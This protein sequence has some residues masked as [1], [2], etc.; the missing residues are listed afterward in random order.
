MKKTFIFF[1]FFLITNFIFSSF[2]YAEKNLDL[3]IKNE[4][5]QNDWRI[6]LI[7]NTNHP[8]N[9]LSNYKHGASYTI[10]Y[11]SEESGYVYIFVVRSN[12]SIELVYPTSEIDDNYLQ[13]NVLY[14]Y[15][16]KG[17]FNL[18]SPLGDESLVMYVVPEK[19]NPKSTDWLKKSFELRRC[20]TE[21]INIAF[22]ED[23]PNR[24]DIL[25]YF[26]QPNLNVETIS[27]FFL[28]V[29]SEFINLFK[30]NWIGNYVTYTVCNEYHEARALYDYSTLTS[31]EKIVKTNYL[32]EN[33]G[34]YTIKLDKKNNVPD[35]NALSKEIA[36]E[37]AEKAVRNAIYKYEYTYNLSDFDVFAGYVETNTLYND[38]WD[39]CFSHNIVE[40]HT[41]DFIVN[42]NATTGQIVH[43]CILDKTLPSIYE[44][45][46]GYLG[47]ERRDYEGN[48][49]VSLIYIEFYE[50]YPYSENIREEMNKH[51]RELGVIP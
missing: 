45:I 23:Y 9:I 10:N 51:E 6:N 48:Y 8:Q 18:Y 43:L 19:L 27:D 33:H 24:L 44:S 14:Y 7:S 41:V 17:F 50:G 34:E 39:I 46:D 20:M 35:D 25:S 2:V 5:S 22:Y 26:Y 30:D 11:K 4:Y 49:I 21:S 12:R 36:V 15:P 28:G 1:C 13:A 3:I 31:E 29:K 32:L 47:K 40:Q 42:I 37:I 16:N 38:W